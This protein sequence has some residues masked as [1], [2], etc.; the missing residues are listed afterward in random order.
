MLLVYPSILL[1]PPN[2]KADL[3]IKTLVGIKNQIFQW[4]SAVLEP[5]ACNN[6]SV[7][8]QMVLAHHTN[9]RLVPLA[10]KV[11]LACGL[12]SA[13]IGL[14]KSF[15]MEAALNCT[16]RLRQRLALE[17]TGL[18]P[19][20]FLNKTGSLKFPL[21]IKKPASA[22]SSG[23]KFVS[24]EMEMKQFLK[25]G[26]SVQEERL[27]ASGFPPNY[28]FLAEEFVEGES[29][30]V[31]GLCRKKVEHIFPPLKQ[32]WDSPAGKITE[33]KLESPPSNLIDS[34]IN[35][36]ESCGLKWCAW[37]VELKSGPN[38]WTVM[39]VNSRLGEDGK[40][41]YKLLGG[42]GVANKICEILS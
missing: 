40:D 10:E 15:S 29:W 9:S 21:I 31:S 18:N 14:K 24:N 3:G 42:A 11:V 28:Q 32:A 6:F 25:N 12:A 26:H 22:R 37:C 2:I 39:E 27:R 19:R 38:N 16:D 13:K 36:V 17:S 8:L 5:G 23:V 7:T 34:A 20:W 1:P 35:A 4:P 30:E 33:Y 41:Y